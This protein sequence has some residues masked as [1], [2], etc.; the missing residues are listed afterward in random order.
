MKK[1][2]KLNIR[3]KV[4]GVWFRGSTEKEALKLNI[5]GWVK[6]NSDGSVTVV[7]EGD[8]EPLKTLIQW[9]KHGPPGARVDDIEVSW[10]D[11][12]GEFETFQ[13]RY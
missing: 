7:A 3:G 9:C 1:R 6:N 10:L 13:I 12:R 8:E 2:V 11:Y 4:Q 5:K